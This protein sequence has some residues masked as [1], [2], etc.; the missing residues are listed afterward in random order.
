M[1]SKFTT[2]PE[3]SKGSSKLPDEV[4]KQRNRDIKCFK[5]H[6]IGHISSQ[7]PNRHPMIILDG[8]EV[9]ID[10]ESEYAEM[11]PL[12]EDNEAEVE[13]VAIDD[14]IGF[15]LVARR[16]LAAHAKVDDVQWKNILY[17]RCHINKTVCS[18]IIDA[19][20]CTNVASAL[21]VEKLVLPTLRHPQLNKLQ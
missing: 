13:E 20:S 21:M 7:C 8:G 6:G 2:K 18:L 3:V 5:C 1:P 9:V 10:D 19:R 15:T 11:P 17:T 12:I 4:S 14:Q 16:A